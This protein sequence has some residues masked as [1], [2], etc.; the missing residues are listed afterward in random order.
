MR[1]SFDAGYLRSIMD[2]NSETGELF[3]KRGWRKGRRAGCYSKEYVEIWV[4]NASYKGHRLVWLW[5]HGAWPSRE[6]DHI[7]C[8]GRNNRISNLRIATR[9]ENCANTRRYVSNSSGFK[10]VDFHK[11]TGKFRARI[12]KDRSL[13]H[14]GFF[15]T[16]EEAF[17]AYSEAA[18][19]RFKDFARLA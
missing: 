6:I 15:E 12:R 11:R 18:K 17:A 19:H 16:P 9:S 4:D 14:L 13:H 3:W 8:N 7:D 2:Y 1:E 10:G 5:V